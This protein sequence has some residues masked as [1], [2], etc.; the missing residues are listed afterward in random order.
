MTRTKKPSTAKAP[1]KRKAR[2]K[3]IIITT[4]AVGATGIIGYFGWQYFKKKRGTTHDDLDSI[5]SNMNQP[6]VTTPVLPSIKPKTKTKTTYTN[7]A[8]DERNDDFPLKK[9]SKGENVRR[10]QEALVTKYGKQT[11]PK[12]GA[13]G[14]FGSEL[15]AALKK[16]GLPASITESTLNVIAQGTTVNPATVGKELYSAANAKDYTKAISLL[17]KMKN[18]DDYT[19]AN[20]VFKQERIS[21]V[22]QTIVNGLLNV[23]STD[24]QK[25]AIK[26]EFLRMGLQ[27]D[28]SKWS[29]S[30][31]DGLPIVTLLPTSVWINATESVK[32]PARM[33]LGNEVSKRLDYTLFENGGKHF[34]VQTKTVKY[35]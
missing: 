6:I 26:F 32:V 17:K 30:G 15:T 25:Q 3:K 19:A 9:G 29:L 27:F 16:L 23:F 35:L 5:I 10:L 28:G 21:G 11:L 7:T 1:S 12:Y 18:T 33:V 22:R 13:D 34:L 14:D 2:K 4:L 20:N 31:L 24:A 8:T